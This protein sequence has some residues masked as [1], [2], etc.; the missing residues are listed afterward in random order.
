MVNSK[1]IQNKKGCA[2]SYGLGRSAARSSGQDRFIIIAPAASAV[3]C[4]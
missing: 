4:P 2:I 1:I 3:P